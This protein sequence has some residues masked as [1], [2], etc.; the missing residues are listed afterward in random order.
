MTFQTLIKRLNTYKS[1]NVSTVSKTNTHTN[2]FLCIEQG[3]IER[4]SVPTIKLKKQQRKNAVFRKKQKAGIIQFHLEIGGRSELIP[5]LRGAAVSQRQA[6]GEGGR[7][8][9]RMGGGLEKG[10]WE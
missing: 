3:I 10:G 7:E 4:Q 1:G 2:D 6:S 5:R 9:R 8:G